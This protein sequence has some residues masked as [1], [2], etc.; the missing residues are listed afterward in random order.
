MGRVRD[1]HK[2]MDSDGLDPHDAPKSLWQSLGI[3]VKY[4]LAKAPL[5]EHSLN[6][7]VRMGTPSD[8]LNTRG[9]LVGPSYTLLKYGGLCMGILRG[10]SETCG[11]LWGPL[12]ILGKDPQDLLQTMRKPDVQIS[13]GKQRVAISSIENHMEP[14]E[15]KLKADGKQRTAARSNGR[16]R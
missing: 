4:G 6:T 13:N 12:A 7:S 14:M 15:S 1:P 9:S 3:I 2:S 10:S 5:L 11:A 16:Q 8:T